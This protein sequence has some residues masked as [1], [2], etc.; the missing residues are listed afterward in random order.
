M[1]GIKL[2]ILRYTYIKQFLRMNLRLILQGRFPKTIRLSTILSGL[3]LLTESRKKQL[4]SYLNR[5]TYAHLNVQ[6]NVELPIL[7]KAENAI[8]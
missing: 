2:I 1:A 6:L 7:S 8:L 3:L 4:N 5:R